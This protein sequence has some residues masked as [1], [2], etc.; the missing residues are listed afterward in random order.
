MFMLWGP[1]E[2]E[3]FHCTDYVTLLQLPHIFGT[4][5]GW[6]SEFSCTLR[7]GSHFINTHFYVCSFYIPY[8]KP[9]WPNC[10]HT[11][12]IWV[13][14]ASLWSAA[15]S[16]EQAEE[17]FLVPLLKLPLTELVSMCCAPG[18]KGMCFERHL[19]LHVNAGP[20]SEP[21]VANG[22]V[23]HKGVH[24][25][26]ACSWWQEPLNS[27]LLNL[28]MLSQLRHWLG[29]LHFIFLKQKCSPVAV[30]ETGNL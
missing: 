26:R 21:G 30:K 15:S 9:V 24:K 18:M 13:T 1:F 5:L 19:L 20:A 7:V 8:A 12:Q 17:S 11:S 6:C 27:D 2:P 22:T 10:Q 29:K 28:E 23:T 14:D 16:E 25:P 3:V 4:Y